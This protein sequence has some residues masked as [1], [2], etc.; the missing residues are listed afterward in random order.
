MSKPATKTPE[1]EDG[2]LRKLPEIDPAE[3]KLQTAGL[4]YMEYFI[5]LPNGFSA[6]DMKEPTC[7]ARVQKSNQP[8][9]KFDRLTLVAAD[10]SW[11]AEAVVG[12]ADRNVVELVAIKIVR[13]STG[14]HDNLFRDE[15]FAVRWVGGFYRVERLADHLLLPGTYGSEAL[16]VNGIKAQY[17]RVA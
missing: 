7:W 1:V 3:V 6:D 5:R 11:L 14:R 13:L 15:N 9:A 17:P 2:R 16:A 8:V 10:E 12:H 4:C